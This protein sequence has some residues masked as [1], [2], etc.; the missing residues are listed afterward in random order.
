MLTLLVADDPFFLAILQRYLHL[1]G[2][3]VESSSTLSDAQSRLEQGGFRTVIVADTL[4]DAQRFWEYCQRQHP[5]VAAIF[6]TS[7]PPHDQRLYLPLPLR[8][9][10]VLSLMHRAAEPRAQELHA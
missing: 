10:Q 6:A 7:T 1:G 2:Y 4:R 3:A 9:E 5:E 8:L